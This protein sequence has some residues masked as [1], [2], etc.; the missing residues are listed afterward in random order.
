M[1]KIILFIFS[2]F[3]WCLLTWPVNFET[4]EINMQLIISGII[5]SLI[6]TIIMGEV[7]ITH[8][9]KNFFLVRF[10]WFVLYIPILFYYM[11]IANFDVL[12]RVIHP[13]MPINPGI[14]KV[15]TIL[16]S[17][18]ARTALANSITLTPGTL[19]VDITE[20]GILYIHCINIAKKN[21]EKFIKDIVTR[22]ENILHKAYE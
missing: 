7:F 14:V 15:Q 16:K 22:F 17:D 6:I 18:T 3:I 10:F 1:R 11:L 2:F 21:R 19:T 13:K 4:Q 9:H 5:I 20:K 8:K 12:Y